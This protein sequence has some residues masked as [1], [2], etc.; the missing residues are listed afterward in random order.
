MKQFLLASSF[1]LVVG[2]G[3]A[4][5]GCSESPAQA[6]AAPSTVQ[7]APLIS[8]AAPSANSP[9]SAPAAP[10]AKDTAEPASSVD[11]SQYRK[12]SFEELAGFE[13]WPY[14]TQDGENSDSNA[15]A[16]A[17]VI[18]EKI[19]ALDGQRVAVTGFMVPIE[20]RNGKI[21]S[22]MLVRNQMA[23]CF[24]MPVS[25]NEWVD[26][27]MAEKRP[28]KYLPDVPL[29]ARGVISVGEKKTE[30]GMVISIYRMVADEVGVSGGF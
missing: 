9:K 7:G 13:Y 1:A 24:G 5:T 12:A 15:P 28:T 2:F 25:P 16:N 10:A 19:R 21:Y 11:A 29:T 3:I 8:A 18:P 14:S 4:S 20:I 17:N 6:Q 30:D 26:V 27:E 23:C 22:F